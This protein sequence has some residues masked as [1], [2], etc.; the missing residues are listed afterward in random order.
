MTWMVIL[1]TVSQLILLWSVLSLIRNTRVYAYRTKL[2]EEISQATQAEIASPS[3]SLWRYKIFS[4]VS[5]IEMVY[6]FW[7]PL[8][9]FYPH[10]ELLTR[11]H[12]TEE[13]YRNA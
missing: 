3:W 4:S 11:P 6:K 7:R 8:D 12:V 10:R 1:L 13:E 2:L 5:Y 9:S